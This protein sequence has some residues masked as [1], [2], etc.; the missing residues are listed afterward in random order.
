MTSTLI[1]MIVKRGATISTQT[2]ESLARSSD[3]VHWIGI[4]VTLLKENNIWLIILWFK[5]NTHGYKTQFSQHSSKILKM[6]STIFS[7]KS[8]PSV[9]DDGPLICVMFRSLLNWLIRRAVSIKET[10]LPIKK[11]SY[12]ST[13][14]NFS[15]F[16]FWLI[17][18]L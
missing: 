9:V 1:K 3:E 12:K 11:Y 2:L 16:Y 6:T 17:K 13:K 18:M 10:E 5:T 14:Q 15:Y 7:L 8:C 4:L